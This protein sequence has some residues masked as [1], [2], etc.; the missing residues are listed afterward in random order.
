MSRIEHCEPRLFGRSALLLTLWMTVAL[1]LLFLLVPA[2]DLLAAQWFHLGGND[3]LWRESAIHRFVKE[4]VRPGLNVFVLLLL[5]LACVSLASRGRLLAWRPRA[6]AYVFL[7]FALGPGLLVNG[8]LK[9]FIGRARPKDIVE[10]GGD[11]LFSTAFLPANQCLGNCSFVS[12]DVAFVAATLAF[13]LLLR[14]WQRQAL[15][16][17]CL[18]LTTLTAY[19]RMAA[20]AHFLS[21]V[22]LG[23]L[24]SILLALFLYRNVVLAGGTSTDQAGAR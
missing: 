21:D 12:G 10:F 23:A 4:V 8:L 11:K 16:W 13:A 9:E 18:A 15:V 17:L 6:I 5:A 2:C 3:F 24:S 22:T 7:T 1:S 19:Y 14:S 20:G